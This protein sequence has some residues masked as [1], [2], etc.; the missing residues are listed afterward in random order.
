M[1]IGS[2][3]DGEEPWKFIGV[4]QMANAWE[5]TETGRRNREGAEMPYDKNASPDGSLVS[6]F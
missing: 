3:R 4:E 5:G 1:Q 6:T 2:R